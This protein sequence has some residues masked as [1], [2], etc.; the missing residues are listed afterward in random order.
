[1]EHVLGVLEGF[2]KVFRFL[3]DLRS[4]TDRPAGTL[5]PFGLGGLVAGDG[6]GQHSGCWVGSVEH[7]IAEYSKLLGYLAC[8]Y[9][10]V[11]FLIYCQF[12]GQDV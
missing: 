12:Q 3:W 9:I 7:S 4:F 11:L 6:K 1:M 10:M 5:S 2:L 8:F